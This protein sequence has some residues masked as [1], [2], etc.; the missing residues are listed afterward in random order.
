MF[1]RECGGLFEGYFV[2]VSTGN[3]NKGYEYTPIIELQ[4]VDPGQVSVR[5][6][7]PM[8]SP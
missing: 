4:N 1:H 6:N 7:G 5:W 3:P 8:N 2:Y